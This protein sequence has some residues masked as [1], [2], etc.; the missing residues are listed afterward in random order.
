MLDNVMGATVARN[1]AV[2]ARAALRA[3]AGLNH[4]TGLVVAA[5]VGEVVGLV[6]EV[7]GLVARAVSE[8]GQNASV[9]AGAFAL[10]PDDP[11]VGLVVVLELLAVSD[12]D[13]AGHG[14]WHWGWVGQDGGDEWEGGEEGFEL[15]FCDCS[16]G[17]TSMG[18]CEDILTR[19]SHDIPKQEQFDIRPMVFS[20][21]P[22]SSGDQQSKDHCRADS[23][24]PSQ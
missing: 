20:N 11:V 21:C 2:I 3:A 15:H 5:A 1:L 6:V 10:D 16:L 22:T 7:E 23:T 13:G 17:W 14:G 8:P 9:G 12:G 4:T 18:T 24:S 19:A